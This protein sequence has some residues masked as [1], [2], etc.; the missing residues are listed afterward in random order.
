MCK[1]CD[2]IGIIVLSIIVH[3]NGR[4]EPCVT[5]SCPDCYEEKKRD[6]VK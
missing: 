4:K 1:T 5:M 6:D 2:G 3:K